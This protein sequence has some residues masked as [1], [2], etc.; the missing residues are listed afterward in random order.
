MRD[1]A[2]GLDWRAATLAITGPLAVLGVIPKT[3]I[4]L[5]EVRELGLAARVGI[6]FLDFELDWP[7]KATLLAAHLWLVAWLIVGRGSRA[8]LSRWS[9]LLVGVQLAFVYAATLFLRVRGWGV[10]LW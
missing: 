5:Q 1:A 4:V 8:T 10:P 9:V 7:W 2:A 6:W 3:W